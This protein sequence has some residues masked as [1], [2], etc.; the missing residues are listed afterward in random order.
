MPQ[1]RR[2]P[3][4]GSPFWE[5]GTGD[6]DLLYDIRSRRCPPGVGRDP[7]AATS[8]SR[9][10]WNR[11]RGVSSC[12][13]GLPRFGRFFAIK[14]GVLGLVRGLARDLAGTGIT[15]TTV[16]PGSPVDDARG[17]RVGCCTGCPGS[18]TARARPSDELSNPKKSRQPSVGR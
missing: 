16:S 1:W 4:G 17:D 14:H 18:R 3:V 7:I 13:V 15:A 12:H 8:P 9:G 10:E 2:Q 6:L 11:A 5:G